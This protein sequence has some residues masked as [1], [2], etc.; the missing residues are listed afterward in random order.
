M[1]AHANSTPAPGANPPDKLTALID[2][3]IPIATE[4]MDHGSAAQKDRIHDVIAHIADM[5]IGADVMVENIRAKARAMR[6]IYAGHELGFEDG[7]RDDCLDGGSR[8]EQLALQVL[9]L[10]SVPQ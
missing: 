4:I 3:M 9:V 1:A 7:F 10:V 2:A 8:A 6:L 5:A